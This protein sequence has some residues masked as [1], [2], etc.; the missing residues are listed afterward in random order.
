MWLQALTSARRKYA[1]QFAG[2]ARP[3]LPRL[4]SSQLTVPD[5][6]RGA[7]G[8]VA[9]QGPFCP[10]R[11][12]SSSYPRPLKS[13]TSSLTEPSQP[14]FFNEA[15][16]GNQLSSADNDS[17]FSFRALGF[18]ALKANLPVSATRHHS[19]RLYYNIHPSS[20][21][22]YSISYVSTSCSCFQYR[23]T[24]DQHSMAKSLHGRSLQPRAT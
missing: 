19:Q 1:P 12:V 20:I 7:S 14:L 13:I 22:V 18:T 23:D 9:T 17:T 21:V 15:V 6:D 4:G 11:F 2:G 10:N 5:S 16:Q 24:L 8:R 3:I